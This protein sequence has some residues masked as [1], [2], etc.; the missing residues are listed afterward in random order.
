MSVYD[1]ETF[2]CGLPDAVYSFLC[3]LPF[4]E[5]SLVGLTLGVVE[6]SLV[7]LTLDVVD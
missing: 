4:S 7:G 1:Y 3:S 5:L 2:L 6:L